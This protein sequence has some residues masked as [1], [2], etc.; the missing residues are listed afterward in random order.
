MSTTVKKILSSPIRDGNCAK[1]A[2]I[3]QIES[4]DIFI[5]LFMDVGIGLQ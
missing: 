5:P 2:S 1:M 3:F 4:G